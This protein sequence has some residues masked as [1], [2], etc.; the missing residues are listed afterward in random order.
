MVWRGTETW[1]GQSHIYMW[2]TKIGRNTSGA[3]GP[4]HRPDNSAQ[5]SRTRKV[6]LH[7]FWLY[8]P[9][10]DGVVEELFVFS[11]DHPLRAHNG[12]R[13][14]SLTPSGFH[15]QG[16][17]WKCTSG[18]RGEI[19][20]TG[21]KVSARRKLPPGQNSRGQT[22]TLPPLQVLPHTNQWSGGTGYPALAIT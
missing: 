14:S 1:N 17:S 7:N 21:N 8:K 9:V 16:T 2:W 18:I 12:L 6:S 4:S 20:M 10:S 22:V 11:G 3:R 19:E 13:I 15:Q 5:G